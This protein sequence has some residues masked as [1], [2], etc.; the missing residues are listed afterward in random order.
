MKKIYGL[1]YLRG[2]AAIGVVTA[3]ATG[4][5]GAPWVPGAAGVDLFFLISGFIMVLIT[6]A[7]SSPVR[8]LLDRFSRV[9]PLYW[10]AT[11]VML[12][13]TWLHLFPRVTL[14]LKYVVLSYL[15]IPAQAPGSQ[16]ILPILPQGWTLNYEIL[17]YFVLLLLL[18]LSIRHIV[19]VLTAAL[20]AAV[21]AGV[22]LTPSDPILLTWTSPLLLEF[23]A[24]AWVAL[25][26][27]RFQF[28]KSSVGIILVGAAIVIFLLAPPTEAPQRVINF[29]I[30]ALLLLVGTLTFEP[31]ISTR[32]R[33][34]LPIL[35]GDA[36][37]SIYIWHSF[38][39][40]TTIPVFRVL[41]LKGS[42][43]VLSAICLACGTGILSYYLLERPFLALIRHTR[44]RGESRI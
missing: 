15:F 2:L 35:L 43:A 41:G 29:G 10:L 38:V 16:E 9:V 33:C 17:F 37:Y 34:R 3:H 31:L 12:L 30:P 20:V 28:P 22:A 21:T 44:S 19:L 26:W 11:T 36:S 14:S 18:L 23:L 32:L 7:G 40:S 4:R 6:P 8:F 25:C 27:Q 42:V 39:I 1:Q 5:Y 24:G 13:G